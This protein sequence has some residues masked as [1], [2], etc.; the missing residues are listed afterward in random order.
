MRKNR[1]NSDIKTL[2]SSHLWLPIK[3]RFWS[4]VHLQNKTADECWLWDAAH[5]RQGYGVFTIGGTQY[6]A[7]R[8]VLTLE[9][10]LN[11][12]RLTVRHLCGNKGCV[13]PAH[14]RYLERQ[15]VKLSFTDQKR[16]RQAY[17]SGESIAFLAEEYELS[18]KQ[19]TT[20]LRRKTVR[21]SPSPS[22]IAETRKNAFLD[23]P[24]AAAAVG[25]TVNTWK[26][27]E[28]GAR[29]MPLERWQVFR[30]ALNLPRMTQEQMREV[31]SAVGMDEDLLAP[32][33]TEAPVADEDQQQELEQEVA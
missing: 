8:I 7:H 12:D 21:P 30:E 20:I 32:E 25:V 14:L 1:I 2:Q 29:A 31:M 13:N 18:R 10:G 26:S 28:Y 22:V 15:N 16:L 11:I 17:R 33:S 6:L 3:A 27:Y 9:K 23:I 4:R 5:T 24:E 19:V